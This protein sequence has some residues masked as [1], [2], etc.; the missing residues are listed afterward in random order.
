MLVS[1]WADG[2]WLRL[3]MQAFYWLLCLMRLDGHSDAYTH[4]VHGMHRP[5]K[6]TL[7]LLLTVLGFS[8]L[9]VLAMVIPG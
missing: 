9:G 7:V 4:Q 2:A 3:K 6:Y 5:L 1:T 8:S